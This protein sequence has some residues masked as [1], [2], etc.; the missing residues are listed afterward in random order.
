MSDNTHSLLK[1]SI[2]GQG[3][4]FLPMYLVSEKFEKGELIHLLDHIEGQIET[5]RAVYPSKKQ[6][7][8]KVRRFIDLVVSEWSTDAS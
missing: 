2:S 5:I 3:I 8:P 6:L 1:T 4:S 7:S